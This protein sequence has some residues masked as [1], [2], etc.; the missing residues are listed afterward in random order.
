MYVG[1]KSCSYSKVAI[2][3]H[4]TNNMLY[5]TKHKNALIWKGCDNIKNTFVC[6]KIMHIFDLYFFLKASLHSAFE[7]CF[8]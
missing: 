8:E 2:Y 7:H 6:L 4:H 3:V 1:I 5:K